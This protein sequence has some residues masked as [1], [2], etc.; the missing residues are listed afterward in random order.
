MTRHH[1]RDLFC[2]LVLACYVA[3]AIVLLAVGCAR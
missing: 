2:L 1:A 3:T